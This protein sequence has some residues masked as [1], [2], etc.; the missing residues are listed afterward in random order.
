MKRINLMPGGVQVSRD[1]ET[2]ISTLLGSCV[3]ACLY[4]PVSGAFGMNHFLLASRS[5]RHQSQPLLSEAGRY[6]VHAM[7]LLINSL[8]KQGAER[9]RLRAK[10]F[11][12]A[13][14]L[15][16]HAGGQFA[17]GDVNARFVQEFLGNEGIPLVASDLGGRLGRQVHF[18]GG[19]F[20]VY[21]K[22]LE[23]SQKREVLAKEE[24]YLDRR[25]S[26]Q[27]RTEESSITFFDD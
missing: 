18:H 2:V 11:G 10:V 23:G 15:S 12:G 1:P 9:H 3:A 7:E 4:D 14:V 16:T 13:N 6:G 20:A 19:S 26:E 5:L 27:A 22:M 21:V 25:L 24:R 17:V 8:L